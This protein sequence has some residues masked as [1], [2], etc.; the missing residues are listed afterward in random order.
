MEQRT[1]ARLSEITNSKARKTLYHDSDIT[2]HAKYAG[3]VTHLVTIN[4]KE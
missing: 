1:R 2:I 4:Y 3:V